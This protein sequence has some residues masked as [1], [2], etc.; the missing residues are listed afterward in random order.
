MLAG[1]NMGG[2]GLISNGVEVN[3]ASAGTGSLEVWIDNI[4]GTGTKIATVDITG[5]GGADTWKNYTAPLSTSGQHD[6]YLRF[7]GGANSFFV[8]TIRFLSGTGAVTAVQEEE[9]FSNQQI[10][11]FPNPFHHSFTINMKGDFNY[12]IYDL[13]GSLLEKGNGQ[14][15][16]SLGSQ[17]KTGVYL[18]KIDDGQN[19]QAFKI[20]KE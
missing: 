1:V 18:V 11:V 2:D 5:S 9:Q 10:S 3:A 15:L 19:S 13:T 20:F 8:N 12:A 7:V 6:V 14:E 4:G 17:L 16:I